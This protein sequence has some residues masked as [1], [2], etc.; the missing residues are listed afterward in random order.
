MPTEVSDEK[1]DC[2]D[3]MVRFHNEQNG[4]FDVFEEFWIETTEVY[5]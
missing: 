3:N 4:E 2:S 5:N 1:T